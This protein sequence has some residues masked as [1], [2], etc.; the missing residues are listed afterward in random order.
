MFH[1]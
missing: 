1:F